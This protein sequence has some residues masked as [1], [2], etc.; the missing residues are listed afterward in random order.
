MA[1]AMGAIGIG[2]TLAGGITSAIGAEK[3]AA[4]TQQSFNYQAGVAQINSTIDLQNA[5][6]ARSQGETQAMQ[7]GLKA[8]QQQAQI[9]NQQAASGL[10]VNSGS[11]VAVQQSQKTITGIDTAQIRSNAA[12]TAYDYDVKSTM[13]LNQSTLDVMAGNNAI[14]A[15]NYAAASS[16]LGSVGSVASKWNQGTTSGLFGS[17]SGGASPTM[18]LAG[19]GAIS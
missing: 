19:I 18:G 3:T 6:Y 5:D 1:A 12:K 2:A 14:T 9:K 10:D 4:A 11:A 15:G 8:G 16:I 17:G 13:D 7:Y